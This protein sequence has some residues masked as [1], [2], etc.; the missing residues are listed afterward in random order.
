MVHLQTVFILLELK[1]GVI[2][3]NYRE[4]ALHRV[5]IYEYRGPRKRQRQRDRDRDIKTDR[6]D[7]ETGKTQRQG[8]QRDREDKEPG[9]T[10]RLGRQR[11]RE[12]TKTE[13]IKRQG[14]Q[15]RHRDREDKET[16]KTKRQRNIEIETETERGITRR[17][18]DII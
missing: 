17:K 9:E 3:F 12:D 1:K 13:K 10:Q 18:D 15:G 4:S 2:N 6:G 7:K 16:G 14:R 5:L 8:R 11:D